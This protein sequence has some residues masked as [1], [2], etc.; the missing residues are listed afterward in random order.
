MTATLDGWFKTRINRGRLSPHP[1]TCGAMGPQ[2]DA[3]HGTTFKEGS[4]EES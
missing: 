4:T 3:K 1:S 2:A